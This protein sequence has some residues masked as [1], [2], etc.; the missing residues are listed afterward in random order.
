MNSFDK[1]VIQE[2]AWDVQRFIDD[3]IDQEVTR[4]ACEQWDN[5]GVSLSV[6][7]QDSI[8][9]ECYD[10]IMKVIR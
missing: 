2:L 4:Q 6:D 10:E 8:Y 7:E 3:R 1:S 9:H 5:E